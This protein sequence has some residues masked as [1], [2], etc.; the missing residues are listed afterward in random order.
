MYKWYLIF[1]CGM[2]EHIFPDLFPAGTFVSIVPAI[3][4]RM[5]RALPIWRV[6]LQRHVSSTHDSLT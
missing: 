2:L 3:D 1:T 6:L 4:P 5:I